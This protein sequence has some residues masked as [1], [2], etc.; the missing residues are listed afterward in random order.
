MTLFDILYQAHKGLRWLIVLLAVLA[1]LK[2]LTIWLGKKEFDKLGNILTKSF[3]GILDLQFL[4]GLILII[5]RAVQMS[6][7]DRMRLEHAVTNVIAIGLVHFS[8]KWKKS[9]GPVRA[10]NTFI[11]YLVAMILI[12]VAVTRMP[13]GWLG[14]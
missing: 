8:A 2:L 6:G 13:N 9:L 11:M 4:L 3:V 12:F 14:N 5:W 1:L 10:R 7:L